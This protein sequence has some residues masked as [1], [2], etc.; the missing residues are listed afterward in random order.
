MRTLQFVLCFARMGVWNDW[1]L[2]NPVR[3][4]NSLLFLSQTA[5][6]PLNTARMRNGI[7]LNEISMKEAEKKREEASKQVQRQITLI[8]SSEIDKCV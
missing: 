4:E 3:S 8:Q 2:K 6:D 7:K 5:T 1:I